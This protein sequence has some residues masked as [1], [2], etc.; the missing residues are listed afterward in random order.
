MYSILAAGNTTE[1]SRV[2][3]KMPHAVVVALFEGIAPYEY[4]QAQ[5][6]G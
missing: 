5:N 3:A 4:L 6:R 2:G 1:I